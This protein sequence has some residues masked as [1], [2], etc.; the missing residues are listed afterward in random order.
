[1]LTGGIV[2]LKIPSH[3][4]RAVAENEFHLNSIERS[5]LCQEAID[6]AVFKRICRCKNVMLNGFSVWR[7]YCLPR[8]DA[9]RQT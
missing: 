8:R 1:M 7:T 4:V 9:G 3:Q 6:V 2:N 5:I